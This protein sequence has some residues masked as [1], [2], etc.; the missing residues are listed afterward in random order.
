LRA[1]ALPLFRPELEEQLEAAVVGRVGEVGAEVAAR[2]GP[3]AGPGLRSDGNL[4]GCAPSPGALA[5]AARKAAGAVRPAADAVRG[6][7]AA[8]PVAHFDE[9][10]FR[11]A[12]G[13]AWVTRGGQLAILRNA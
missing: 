10:G 9:T 11:V 13:L 1:I 2:A 8:A 5:S 4:F 7:L 12:G 3:V 6:A